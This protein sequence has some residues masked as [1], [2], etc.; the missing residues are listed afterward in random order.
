MVLLVDE[1][2]NAI[3]LRD[4]IVWE[5]ERK[6][7]GVASVSAEQPRLGKKRLELCMQNLKDFGRV[8]GNQI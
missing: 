4:R 8:L 3:E 7:E 2:A 5:E 1:V 6:S